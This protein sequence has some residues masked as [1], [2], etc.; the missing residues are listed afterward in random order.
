MAEMI[1]M[2][3]GLRIWVDLRNHALD[4]GPHPPD[5]KEEF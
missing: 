4:G 5:E 2:P 1:E 3:F